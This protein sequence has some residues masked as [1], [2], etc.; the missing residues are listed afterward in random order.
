MN[1]QIEKG[2]LFHGEEEED[3]ENV[4]REHVALFIGNYLAVRML[5][6]RKESRSQMTTS[7]CLINLPWS[8]LFTGHPL[9]LTQ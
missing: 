9:N 4:R 2:L 6:R 7:I 5:G 1:S 8:L 3:V